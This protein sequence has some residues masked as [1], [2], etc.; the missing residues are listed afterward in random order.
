MMLCKKGKTLIWIL[1]WS[2]RKQNKDEKYQLC[3]HLAMQNSTFW[4]QLR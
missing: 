3:L 2:L 1:Q 4:L